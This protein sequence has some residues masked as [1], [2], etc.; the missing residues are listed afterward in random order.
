[1]RRLVLI[2]AVCLS[3]AFGA[4]AD[5]AQRDALAGF[6][7]VDFGAAFETVKKRL[8]ANAKADTDP[9]DAS[10]KILLAKAS[11]FG[12]TF[13]VNYT[14]A[15]AGNFSAAYGVAHLPTG[16]F[17]VCQT[18]WVK[19]LGRVE[20]E[21]GK[22]DGNLNTLGAA[23]PSQMITYVFGDGAMIEA[24]IMGCLLT[25]SYLSPAAAK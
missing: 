9:V 13:S 20:E 18:R 17:G 5:P 8:G 14:F 6:D 23:V 16:D 15:A 21:W 2:V 12:E 7:G 22:P 1:M 4:Q 11:Y 19:V 3:A 25:L 10:I 24:G